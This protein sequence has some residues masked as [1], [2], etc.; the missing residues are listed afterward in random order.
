MSDEYTNDDLDTEELEGG[1]DDLAEIGLEG[2]D[3]PGDVD[4][5]PDMEVSEDVEDGV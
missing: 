4:L 5:E 3:A 1:V 2:P